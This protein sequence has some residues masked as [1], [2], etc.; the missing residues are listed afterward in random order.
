LTGRI[1]VLPGARLCRRPAAAR[2]KLLNVQINRELLR[3]V[4]I[5]TVRA[6]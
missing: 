2:G 3:L 1:R 5:D 4:E 6:P